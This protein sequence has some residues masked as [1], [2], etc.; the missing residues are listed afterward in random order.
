[1]CAFI[2]FVKKTFESRSFCTQYFQLL[3]WFCLKYIKG[4]KVTFWTNCVFPL[5]R[6]LRVYTFSNVLHEYLI[7]LFRFN[8]RLINLPWLRGMKTRH[9]QQKEPNYLKNK[10]F[11]KSYNY[12]W[13]AYKE[14]SIKM[15]KNLIFRAVFR[16]RS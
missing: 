9:G 1:M 4:S 5:K 15:Q 11:S 16:K 13:N 8:A 12:F 2:T 6:V 10:P 14:L 3:W 7:A